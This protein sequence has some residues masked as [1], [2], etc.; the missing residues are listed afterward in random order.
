MI[1]D[2]KVYPQDLWETALGQWL[3]GRLGHT[4]VWWYSSRMEPDMRCKRCNED[5]G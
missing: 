3:C 5:L 1:K 4:D 2:W